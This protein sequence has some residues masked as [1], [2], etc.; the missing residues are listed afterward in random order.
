MAQLPSFSEGTLQQCLEIA[1]RIA[2]AYAGLFPKQRPRVHAAFCELLGALVP[3]QVLLRGF[4]PRFVARL[5]AHTLRP[6]D[7]G[8]LQTAGTWDAPA[9]CSGLEPVQ[10]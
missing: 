4:L 7:A 3:D 10:H 2:R 1:D 9:S 6:P 8:A 5:L